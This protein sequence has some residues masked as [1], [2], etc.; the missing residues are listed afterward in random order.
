MVIE[1][2][3]VPAA[4]GMEADWPSHLE[5]GWIRHPIVQQSNLYWG[6]R[7]KPGNGP[8]GLTTKIGNNGFMRQKLSVRSSLEPIRLG[9][10]GGARFGIAIRVLGLQ[11]KRKARVTAVYLLATFVFHH[12]PYITRLMSLYSRCL[13]PHSL[14]SSRA[15][16]LL[17]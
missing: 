11:A 9:G 7:W 16:G 13:E 3:A 17:A 12:T 6:L 15:P 5:V 10:E 14:S 8:I 4:L 2:T 1:R